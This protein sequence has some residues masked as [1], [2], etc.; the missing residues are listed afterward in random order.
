MRNALPPKEMPLSAQADAARAPAPDAAPRPSLSHGTARIGWVRALPRL[1]QD[2]GIDANRVIADCDIAPSLFDCDYNSIDFRSA[3]RLLERCVR[4]TGCPHFALCLGARFEP[5]ALGEIADL[6]ANA[7]TV[8][9]ALRILILRFHLLDEGAVPMLTPVTRGRAVFAHAIYT[10][11]VP[12]LDQFADLAAAIGVRILTRLCGSSFQP[13]KVALPHRAPADRETF[14]RVLGRN[15]AF[16]AHMTSVV[17]DAWWLGRPIAGAGAPG[18][19]RPASPAAA[20]SGACGMPL[21]H[22][23][24]RALRPMM[25]TATATESAAARMFALHPRTLRRRLRAEG[26]SFLSL[27]NET[28]LD[29]ARQLLRDTDLRVSEIATAL[30]YSDATALTRAFRALTG[31]AP[32]AWRHRERTRAAFAPASAGSAPAAAALSRA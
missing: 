23:V 10:R 4:E 19:A 27:L 13:L 1:L 21:S 8:G 30:H 7:A 25:F 24:R 16:N 9:D 18:R 3:G 12:A 28:R 2:F 31:V 20:A 32:A 22:L 14:Q 17:F 6:M 29:M 15:V 11:D 26:E 5:A